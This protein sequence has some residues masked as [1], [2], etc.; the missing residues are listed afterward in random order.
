MRMTIYFPCNQ[1]KYVF[2]FTQ[3]KWALQIHYDPRNGDIVEERYSEVADF[4]YRYARRQ[5][6]FNQSG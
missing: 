1:V 4:A 6:F 3:N 2:Y 5:D